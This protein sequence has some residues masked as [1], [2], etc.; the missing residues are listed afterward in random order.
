MSVVFDWFGLPDEEG[1]KQPEKI[2]SYV[3]DDRCH[4]NAMN[5]VMIRSRLLQKIRSKYM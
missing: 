5:L 4:M 1:S 3:C 2:V